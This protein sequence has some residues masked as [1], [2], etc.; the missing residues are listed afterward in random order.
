MAAAPNAKKA[1]RRGR[2]STTASYNNL[3]SIIKNIENYLQKL[4]TLD[5]DWLKAITFVFIALI[6]GSSIADIKKSER[7]VS[8]K[9]LS[10]REVQADLVLW[11]IKSS[12]TANTLAELYTSIDKNQKL[13][14]D[15]LK[16]HGIEDKEITIKQP[17]INDKEAQLYYDNQNHG[18]R[19]I[20]EIGILVKSTKI[21]KVKDAIQKTGELVGQGISL[22][23]TDIEYIYTKLNDI[24]PEMIAEA[25]KQARL[26]AQQFAKDSHTG[27]AGI[28]NAYQGLFSI[29]PVHYYNPEIKKVRVVTDIEYYL[30]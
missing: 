22:S 29:D 21:D 15:F 6:I 1:L 27:I 18:Q 8:V 16:K 26:A 11:P 25:T 13:I 14:V 10:E 20:A 9:G 24:K 7:Y 4:K 23:F 17:Q 2:H 19:Y 28:K 3:M 30:R 12:A 5:K